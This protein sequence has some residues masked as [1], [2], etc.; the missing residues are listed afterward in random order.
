MDTIIQRSPGTRY[1][2]RIAILCLIP[3]LLVAAPDIALRM[4]VDTVVPTAGQ[5]VEFTITASNVGTSAATALQVTDQLPAEL[6]IPTGMAA[7][8]SAGTYDPV[9][10]VWSIGSLSAGGNA[11]LVIPAVVAVATQP[12]CSVNVAESRLAADTNTSNDRAMAAV[13][14]GLTGTSVPRR[15]SEIEGDVEERLLLSMGEF[16]RVLGG[17]IVPGSIVLIGGDPGIA[18]R[19]ARHRAP[20]FHALDREAARDVE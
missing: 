15:L 8:P 17:G 2:A 7:F 14:R 20:R 5:P 16:A 13:K 9:T 19:H 11:T 3:R 6:R 12:P 18:R 1:L 4:T 10:G